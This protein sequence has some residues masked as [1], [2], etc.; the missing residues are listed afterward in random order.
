[1]NLDESLMSSTTPNSL[2]TATTSTQ[3]NDIG[4]NIT[5]TYLNEITYVKMILN[6]LQM[7]QWFAL[8]F[9]LDDLMVNLICISKKKR[10]FISTREKIMF[11]FVN[12]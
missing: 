2:L 10:I 4:V 7:S 5:W 11:L 8:A 12:V 1:V 6:N 9:S 3:M